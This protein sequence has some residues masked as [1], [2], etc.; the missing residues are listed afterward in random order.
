MALL[1]ALVRYAAAAAPDAVWLDLEG[2]IQYAYYT[3]DA[4]ALGNIRELAA[5]KEERSALR[6][7][8][9]ALASYRLAQLHAAHAD[10]APLARSA[11]DCVDQLAESLQ[12]EADA[13]EALALQ[14]ACL[15]LLAPLKTLTAPLLASRGSGQMRRALG[16][17]PRNPRVL[18]LRAQA[19]LAREPRGAAG[20]EHL[21]QAVAAFEHE[22]EETARAPGW[23]APEAYAIL[24]RVYLE[25][26][27]AIAARA[28]LE[29]ALLLAP[30]CGY[31]HRL[32]AQITQG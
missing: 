30:D 23:G 1:A 14:S 21:K 9:V 27:D 6:F 12:V 25:H 13:P 15:D 17:A 2:R 22:R 19:E 18:L 32:M 26:G 16:A 3:E 31:A 29:H 5:A 4:R 11:R 28:A 24:G 7:Y 10:R 20:L 8:Y